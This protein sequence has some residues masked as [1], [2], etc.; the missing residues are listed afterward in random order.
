V[1]EHRRSLVLEH[2]FCRSGVTHLETGTHMKNWMRSV[3]PV[4][5]AATGMLLSGTAVAAGTG[6]NTVGDTSTSSTSST[7]AASSASAAT[8]GISSSAYWI[9][10]SGLPLPVARALQAQIDDQI[11]KYGGVQISPY[12]VAYNG[13]DPIMVFA[14]PLTGDFP[15]ASADRVEARGTGAAG[16][17][18]SADQQGRMATALTTSYRYGCPYNET[19]GW[20]CFYQNLSFNNYSCSGGSPCADGGRM[21]QFE[22][23]GTQSL[24]T[25]GFA[26]MTSSWVNNTSSYVAVYNSARAEIWSESPGAAS[27]NVGSADD[28]Q[29][30]TFWII[31]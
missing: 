12:E 17:S 25:Y 4:L 11:A 27:P 22:S 10:R 9:E 5:A 8:P 24:A 21:L 26:A 14:N 3:L 1:R 18:A 2:R 20:D 29:A 31:C 16:P 15:T 30:Y 23:C 13:G 28:D 6:N 7:S 19:T